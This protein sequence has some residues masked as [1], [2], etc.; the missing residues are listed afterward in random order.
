MPSF[1]ET[2]TC[3]ICMDLF[4]DPRLLPCSHTFCCK[5]IHSIAHNR[6]FVT[7]PLCR[8]RF[9]VGQILPV[10]RIVLSLVEQFRQEQLEENRSMNI[11]AKCYD[12]KSYQKLELCCHCD[13]LLCNKCHNRHGMDWKARDYRTNNL[14]L[15]KVTWLKFQVNFKLRHEKTS[16][17][18]E[19]LHD[20]EYKLRNYRHPCNRQQYHETKRQIET[21]TNDLRHIDMQLKEKVVQNI[22]IQS[23]ICITP[24]SASS[25]GYG[26][27]MN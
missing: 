22:N 23:P 20:I 14:L 27:D 13:I 17:L 21:I 16:I 24:L 26:S 6:S 2:L 10:N 18:N 5:C 19:R 1:E 3:P 25:S 15:S 9:V 11:N 12:C 8:Y 4:D 7:C